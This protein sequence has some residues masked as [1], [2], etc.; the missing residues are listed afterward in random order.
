[1][2]IALQ[3]IGSLGVIAFWV[4]VGLRLFNKGMLLH[5]SAEGWWRASI[6]LLTIG[7]LFALIEILNELRK[8]NLT[9]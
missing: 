3:V 9:T 7:I 5:A 2:K 1:M 6:G 4:G 8:R